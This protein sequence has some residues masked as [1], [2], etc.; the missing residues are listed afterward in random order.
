MKPALE[1]GEV[2][3]VDHKGRRFFAVVEALG[4]QQLQ[5]KPIERHNTW[6]TARRGHRDLPGQ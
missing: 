3:E 6:R 1:P 5:I 4:G 2:V